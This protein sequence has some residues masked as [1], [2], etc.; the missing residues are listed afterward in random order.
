ML[1]T[2]FYSVDE[3]EDHQTWRSSMD[4]VSLSK[5]KRGVAHETKSVAG[6]GC[7]AEPYHD[8]RARELLIAKVEETI[9]REL[10]RLFV[11]YFILR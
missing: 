8:V 10:I 2:Q 9:G 3:S 6:A 5:F 4:F 7:D 1:S 11:W